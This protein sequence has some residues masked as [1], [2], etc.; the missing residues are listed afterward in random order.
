MVKKI[1]CKDHSQIGQKDTCVCENGITSF[2]REKVVVDVKVD[3]K[4]G[5]V[6]FHSHES[7]Q[8]IEIDLPPGKKYYPHFTLFHKDAEIQCE[9][10]HEEAFGKEISEHET[11]RKF[12]VKK[13]AEENEIDVSFSKDEVLQWSSLHVCDWLVAIPELVHADLEK[14]RNAFVEEDIDGSILVHDL[15][16]DVLTCDLDVHSPD[17][18][19]IM[20]LINELQC[21]DTG[22]LFKCTVSTRI[23]NQNTKLNRHNNELAA[24]KR[25][26]EAEIQELRSKVVTGSKRELKPAAGDSEK[27]K[28]PN[29]SN[30]SVVAVVLWVMTIAGYALKS[31]FY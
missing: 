25:K 7:N 2:M 1:S 17:R 22:R 9:Y 18:D 21:H 14:Y 12:R 31:S 29:F 23:M 28:V 27:S 15:D 4:V 30:M 8:E 19:T 3:P 11:I 16:N 13:F 24:E 6:T 10:I 5:K 26:L 20:E